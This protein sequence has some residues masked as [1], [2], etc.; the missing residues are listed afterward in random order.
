[1]VNLVGID[2]WSFEIGVLFGGCAT[3]TLLAAAFGR[4]PR[5][6][7]PKL[8]LL[9]AIVEGFLLLMGYFFWLYFLVQWD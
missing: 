9:L 1:M 3:L 5:S 2:F 4:R 6:W 7:T 8:V